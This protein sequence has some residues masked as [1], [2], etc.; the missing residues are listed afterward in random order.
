[1]LSPN[2]PSETETLGT[3]GL[4]ALSIGKATQRRFW[5]W[6]LEGWRRSHRGTKGCKRNKGMGLHRQRSPELV[7]LWGFSQQCKRR[8]TSKKVRR[9]RHH[10]AVSCWGPC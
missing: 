7:Q 2:T 3:K 4:A 10:P 1:M 8:P 9:A 5:P 6:S